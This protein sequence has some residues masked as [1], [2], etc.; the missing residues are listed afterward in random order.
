VEEFN[1]DYDLDVN[2][3]HVPISHNT[4]PVTRVIPALYARLLCHDKPSFDQVMRYLKPSFFEKKPKGIK[5]EKL[6]HLYNQACSIKTAQEMRMINDA[7]AKL[8]VNPP[9]YYRKEH[10]CKNPNLFN[11]CSIF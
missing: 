10:Y 8:L 2:L 4:Q 3:N 1:R 7:F 6:D 9:V 11:T 5:Q